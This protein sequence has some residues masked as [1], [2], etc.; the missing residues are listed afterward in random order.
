MNTPQNW[1]GTKLMNNVS[2]LVTDP[3]LEWNKNK[4]IRGVQRF[5]V[6]GVRDR[7]RIKGEKMKSDEELWVDIIIQD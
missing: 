4:I 3:S 7:V 5:E 6:I 2:D 1:D